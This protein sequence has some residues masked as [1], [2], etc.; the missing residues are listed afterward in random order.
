MASVVRLFAIAFLVVGLI[1]CGGDD[2]PQDERFNQ[3]VD[4]G[5]TLANDVRAEITDLE[6][7]TD[8]KSVGSGLA[9]MLGEE[10]ENPAFEANKDTY[11][12]I[13]AAANAMA[14]GDKSKL[15]EIQKLADSLPK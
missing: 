6:R 5:I 13:I 2:G 10:M 15:A 11:E 8:L 7:G 1:G 9:E 12:K 4:P 3:T 14:G